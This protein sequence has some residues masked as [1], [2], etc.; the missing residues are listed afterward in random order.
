MFLLMGAEPT[1]EE[2]KLEID[3]LKGAFQI[4]TI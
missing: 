2:Q 3:D 1:I 4:S